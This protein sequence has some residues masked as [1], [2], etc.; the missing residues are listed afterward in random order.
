M[1]IAVVEDINMVYHKALPLPE[2]SILNR[3]RVLVPAKRRE[4]QAAEAAE[5][6]EAG[7]SEE[8]NSPDGQDVATASS[9]P[10]KRKV[11][12]SF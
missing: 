2:P 8:D 5:A 9:E 10:R 1:A 12:C 4:A 7:D 3:P 11:C 6:A